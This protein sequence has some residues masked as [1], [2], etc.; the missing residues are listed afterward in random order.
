MDIP[1]ADLARIRD[2]YTRGL[3]RQAHAAA[4]ALG[5]VRAWAGTAARLLG[6]RLAIQLGAPKLG[7]R[8]HLAGFRATPA[9][10][11]A[12]YYHARYRMERFG[13]LS[14]WRFMRDHPDWSDAPPELHADWVSLAG[15]VAAR[16]RD[17]DR[18]DRLLNRAEGIAPDRPWPCIERSSAYEFADRLD[19]ALAAAGRSLALHPWFRPG[20][21]SFAHVLLRLGRDREALDFL[22]EADGRIESGL[23]AA[24]LAA[25]QTDL[26]HHADARRTL[27]RYAELSPLLEPELAKWLAARR[28]DAT[29]FLGDFAAAAGY[30][31]EVKEAFFDRFAGRLDEHRSAGGEPPAPAAPRAIRLTL[32]PGPA[33]TVYDLLG[34]FWNHPLPGGAEGGPPADGLPDA[35]ERT[36]AEAAGWV[37]REF[38]L[39]LG[40]AVELVGRGVPFVFTLVEAGFSQP[41][42]CV[43]ADPVR[44][45]VAV[46]D[47]HDRRPVDAPLDALVERFARGAWP[48][49]RPTGRGRWRTSRRSPTGR[50]GSACTP[51]RSRS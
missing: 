40:A 34:R 3:Y 24:Q 12:I 13:P 38:T 49:C 41:R 33:Q 9:H 2:L 29:Y 22:T 4:A 28:A 21:Q 31:R 48:W 7:R 50:P 36:R 10:P 6:G 39:A 51:C 15:F 47:G 46:V 44:G 16:L 11:E 23:V 20:V 42:L 32:P 26:G 30:A 27:D 43:G 18:A 35:A 25:L 1:P 45:T 14:A 8:L 19:D 37:A 17:F 5:P